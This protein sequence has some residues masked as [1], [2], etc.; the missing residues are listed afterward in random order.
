MMISPAFFSGRVPD[1]K[2]VL[3]IAKRFLQ[4]LRYCSIERK[5]SQV[6]TRTISK[7]ADQNQRAA[8]ALRAGGYA[9]VL[10]LYKDLVWLA[11]LPQHPIKA[12]MLIFIFC[13][14][15]AEVATLLK[16]VKGTLEEEGTQNNVRTLGSEVILELAK[17]ARE[18]S[19]SGD[20]RIGNF[21]DILQSFMLS[22][23][24]SSSVKA[25]QPLAITNLVQAE[26]HGIHS[27]GFRDSDCYFHS[28]RSIPV[29][30]FHVQD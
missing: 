24:I 22:S 28:P 15:S 29:Y 8:A 10:P 11:L 3:E 12:G 16:M 18:A 19:E 23:V 4:S 1:S 7:S 13:R 6:E 25:W 2:K 9:Q 26:S 27:L 30:R 21:W 20:K 5:P 17:A 14:A